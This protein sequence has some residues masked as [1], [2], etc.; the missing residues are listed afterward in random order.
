MKTYKLGEV[1]ELSKGK[2]IT[3]A[4]ARDGEVPVIGGGLGPTY[5]HN[6]ANRKSP[7]IT[8]SAS[9]ANAGF[10]N[11]WDLPI[12]ASDCTTIIEKSGSP[13]SIGYIYKYLQSR[14]DFINSELRRGSAQPHVYPSD[15]ANLEIV[16]PS[17]EL[18]SQ[19]VARLDRLFAEI[20]LLEQNFDTLDSLINECDNSILGR[21]LKSNSGDIRGHR[22][23]TLG[24]V[25]ELISRGI[26][27]SYLDSADT[28]V[29]N[30]RCIRDGLVD[31]TYSRRHDEKTKRVKQSKLLQTGDGLINSTGVGTLGRTALFNKVENGEVTVDSHVTIV[32]PN[33]KVLDSNYFGLVLR[34][35][36]NIFVSLSTGTSG[37]TE[38]P[39]EAIKDSAISFPVDLNDQR[40]FYEYY[41]SLNLKLIESR[42]MLSKKRALTATLRASLLSSAFSEQ[43]VVA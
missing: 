28:V 14:Q 10:V 1:C 9:G 11:Y 27:P 17:L 21:I 38:L 16:L 36:E 7:V 35:L 2:T 34:A 37:Q 8:I 41:N 15:I 40:K 4:T 33:S 3:R 31:L 19:I 29:I 32:R 20:K 24:E 26:S 13:A 5:Y 25:T 22:N 30:Q 6:V 39:R 23:S 18:Q 42:K 43:G 12:W